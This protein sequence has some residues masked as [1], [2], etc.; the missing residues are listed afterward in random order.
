VVTPEHAI[1]GPASAGPFRVVLALLVLLSGACRVGRDKKDDAGPTGL[2]ADKAASPAPLDT[3]PGETTTTVGPGT[4]ST[5]A[6]SG[7]RTTTT[8]AGSGTAT[9]ATTAPLAP[10][11]DV[12]VLSDRK[13]DAGIQQQPYSDVLSLRIEDNGTHA[14]FTVQFAGD[15]PNPMP[16]GQLLNVGVDMFHG[17]KESDYQLFAQ[18]D[19]SRWLAY[20]QT[21]SGFVEYPGTFQIGGPKLVFTVPWSSIGGRKGGTTSVFADWSDNTTLVVAASSSDK[22]PDGTGTT[23]PYQP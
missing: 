21:P 13:D 15:L 22:L 17:Q 5:T 19:E 9:T 7:G 6:G 18:G 23:S 16:V 4:S 11:H 1:K 8:R 10:F 20:L 2:P 12:T 14:R 3:V